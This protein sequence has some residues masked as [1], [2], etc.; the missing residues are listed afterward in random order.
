VTLYGTYER[1]LTFQNSSQETEVRICG[2]ENRPC[3]KPTDTSTYAHKYINFSPTAAQLYEDAF[4][5]LNLCF[6]CIFASE[7]I[8]SAFA[9]GFPGVL[10]D[11]WSL[12][13]FV[14]VA[15]GLLSYI[16]KSIPAFNSLR[17]IRVF[18]AVKL[19]RHAPQL[20]RIVTALRSAIW[21]VCNSFVLFGFVSMI[22]AV[23]AVHLFGDSIDQNGEFDTFFQSL[24]TM[25]QVST[26]SIYTEHV[27]SN[28]N[29]FYTF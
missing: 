28:Q 9:H 26:H 22:F 27:L 3:T 19:L 1:V 25:Y 16:E 18:R 8:V 6:T 24:F 21:P 11:F 17:I 12:F 20:Q 4:E 7:V 15:I 2:S 5:I 14:I 23:L 29:T 13:D 10:R